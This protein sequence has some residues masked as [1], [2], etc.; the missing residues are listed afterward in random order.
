MTEQFSPLPRT[1]KALVL[2][3][4]GSQP[5]LEELPVPAPK[6]GEVLVKIHASP[7]NPSDISF[8]HGHYHAGEKPMPVIPGF[9]GS[10][11]VVATGRDFFSRRLMGKSVSCFAPGNGNGTWAQYMVTGAGFAIPMNKN[12]GLDQGSMLMVNPLSAYAM[13]GIAIKEKH[14]AIANTAAASALGQIMIRICKDKNLPLINIVRRQEQLLLLKEQ[15]A[16]FVI[17][18][19]EENFAEKL[20][21][22]FSSQR[23]TLAFD[24][25]AG[26]MA[27]I[28]A[29]AL[30]PGGTVTVYGG[31]SQ[32]ACMINPVNLIFE[33]KNIKGFWLSEWITRQN[34]ITMIRISN[35]IQKNFNKYYRTR[36]QKQVSLEMFTEGLKVYE[37]KMTGGKVLV[38]P[39]S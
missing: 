18:S 34:M 8:I 13:V 9:E 5:V 21:Q 28:L 7:I 19:S 27:G 23:V 17:S 24:A 4:Y 25:I 10:G 22:T 16:E 36:I 15:G 29:G 20:K 37:D 2:H 14:R 38:M 26:E 35:T 39:N 31:L 1:M 11:I 6:K 3:Q 12:I 32:S 30:S 33:N